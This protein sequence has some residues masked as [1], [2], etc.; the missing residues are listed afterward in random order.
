MGS[1]AKV[2]DPRAAFAGASGPS[3]CDV[4]SKNPKR[5]ARTAADPSKD[6]GVKKHKAVLASSPDMVIAPTTSL[7]YR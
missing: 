3:V 6:V 4:F 1:K 2:A 5:P 7:I